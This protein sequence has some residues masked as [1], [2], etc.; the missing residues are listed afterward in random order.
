MLE[1]KFKLLKLSLF[2]LSDPKEREEV[3][4]LGTNLEAEY[5]KGK[6]CPETG[7][8]PANA[9]RSEKWNRCWHP[10]AIPKK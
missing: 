7:N 9:S 4:K 6:A 3:A 5:G 1:R 8:M 2:S 10:A